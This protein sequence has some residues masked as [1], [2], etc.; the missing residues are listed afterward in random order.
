MHAAAPLIIPYSLPQRRL[1]SRALILGAILVL[2]LC[3]LA[4]AGVLNL[5]WDAPTTN[6][7]GTALT[8]L[9]GY[10]VYFGFSS[11][12][13]PGSSSQEV[14]S[15]TSTPAT[16]DVIN[17]SL[18]GLIIGIQYCVQVTAI[19]L[20][21][22]ESS[23]SNIACG[24]T[25]QADSGSDTTPPS[26]LTGLTATAVSF[27]QIN[28]SW[29]SSTDDV[30]VAG[31]AIS[32]GGTPIATTP[33]TNYSDV[34]LNPSTTYTYAVA[35]YD[36]AGN[37]G[38]PNTVTV[39]TPSDAAPPTGSLTI[40]S[41]APYSPWT[42]VTLSLAATDNVGVT[43]YYVSMSATPPAATAAGWVAVTST[44]SFASNVPYTLPSG[45][46]TKTVYAWYE[47]AAGNVS[48]TASASI[49]LAQTLPTLS[50]TSPTS[51]ST[52]RTNSS[53][54]SLAGTAADNVGVTS[55]TWAN[56]QGG[57]GTASGTT[58]WTASGITL[59]SGTNVI[60]VTAQDAAGNKGTATLTV[61]YDEPPT[62][63]GIYRNG[64]WYLDL[65][66]NG[67]FDGCVTTS[68]CL[69]WG[70]SDGDVPVVG[71]WTG[72]G[73]TKVGI[74]RNGT[75]YLDLTGNGLYDGC[76]TTSKCLSWGGDPTDQAVVGRW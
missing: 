74:Y 58:N 63:V 62:K 6:T 34:G 7:D 56:S 45:D 13:F 76:V 14:S 71:D 41:G 4:Q 27:S 31:Y 12:Y 18:T 33:S 44:T 69:S 47:D 75:W 40:N 53:P 73:T 22:N 26:N 68:K 52:Y 55:V 37:L 25:A 59:Q 24:C 72:N 30:G 51:A 19:N 32:R 39:T 60:T 67:I 57:S 48:A 70:G 16:G 65:T 10:R 49:S 20:D 17:Y 64:T 46:G 11:T 21:G 5:A 28:L 15:S 29:N 36:A 8:N 3:P 61:T 38:G 23:G 9:A 42:A 66:G 2:L 50:I 54:L 43:G 1:L 35:A